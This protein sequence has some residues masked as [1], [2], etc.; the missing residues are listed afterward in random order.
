[1]LSKEDGQIECPKCKGKGHLGSLRKEGIKYYILCHKCFGRG[2]L[3][4]VSNVIKEKLD[5]SFD[6][7]QKITVLKQSKNY[8][9]VYG[10]AGFFILYNS[11]ESKVKNMM[12]NVMLEFLFAAAYPG[13]IDIRDYYGS[14]M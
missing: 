2:K 3:D 11:K 6:V 1:M 9:F 4:W 7:I 5:G 8:V 12:S 10:G 14:S 13:I